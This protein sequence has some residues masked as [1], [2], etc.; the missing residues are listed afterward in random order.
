MAITQFKSKL[1]TTGGKYNKLRK[2]KKK[3]FGNDFIPIKIDKNKVKEVRTYGGNKKRRILR[4]NKMNLVDT[5]TGKGEIVKI[6][7]V[8]ENTAN[9]HFVRMNIMTKGAVVE[10]EKGL[11]K[12]VSRPGQHGI[13]NGVLIEKK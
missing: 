8:K 10:T 1:K 2:K 11:A 4:A 12:I 3:D 9:P 6:I 5:K 13:I 7:S